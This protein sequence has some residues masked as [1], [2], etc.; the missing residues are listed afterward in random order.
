MKIYPAN[1]KPLAAALAL[2]AA[3]PAQADLPNGTIGGMA[4][5]TYD[6]AAWATM[7]S[8]GKRS[9]VH[10]VDLKSTPDPTSD[11][12][13]NR[14]FYPQLFRD[15]RQSAL[16]VASG[17]AS[18]DFIVV[19]GNPYPEAVE[20]W[21]IFDLAQRKPLA[22]PE[23]GFAMPVDPVDA[24]LPIDWGDGYSQ[25][26]YDPN[27]VNQGGVLIRSVIGLGGGFR[28]VSDF[29]GQSGSLWFGGLE[30]REQG[31]PDAD[32]PNYKW[33]L[34][35]ST[36]AQANATVFELIDPLFGVDAQG[37]MTLE[38]DYKWGQTAWGAFFG[39]RNVDGSTSEDGNKV[40][41][42]LSINPNRSGAP[43]SSVPLP[44][45]VWLFGS[46]LLGLI[47]VKRRI[48]NISAV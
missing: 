13:G 27:P 42:H 10:G 46:A 32:D 5:F 18:D 26:R 9:D 3:S 25:T 38:A 41:G 40:L 23:G 28:M 35:A 20:Q 12:D 11:T 21:R 22:Q 34:A 45:A 33:Y 44:G 19:R 4:Y 8:S 47:G 29:F 39:F 24:G 1:L 48:A 16:I 30:L 31:Q 17:T 14:F 36:P 6:Q 37:R 7:K 43:V 2:A 15:Y